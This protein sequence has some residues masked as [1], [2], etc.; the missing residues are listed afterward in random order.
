MGIADP[1]DDIDVVGMFFLIEFCLTAI[2]IAAACAFPNPG[3]SWFEKVEQQL[4]WLARSRGLAVVVVGL[5]ALVARAALLPIEGIPQ[6]GIHDEF[7]YLLAADTFTH[8]RMANPTHPCGSTLRRSTSSSSP[9]IP[10]N[11]LR[12][13]DC[14][15]R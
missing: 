6:P 4:G 12:P 2:A 8:G 3:A 5:T 1:E 13:R 15:S 10:R 14:S 7:S 11:I 9:L